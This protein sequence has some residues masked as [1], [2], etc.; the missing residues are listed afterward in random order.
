[1]DDRAYGA[2][3]QAAF[4]ADPVLVDAIRRE[5]YL[6]GEAL[7]PQRLG[8][9]DA[10][11]WAQARALAHLHA[12][13]PDPV[14]RAALT[15]DYELGCKRAVF[16]DDYYP[17]IASGAITLEPSALAAVRGAGRGDECAV[18]GAH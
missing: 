18:A 1:R 4:D 2:D 3:E 17:A 8:D 6:A 5:A 10:L 13:M 12:Q 7:V 16:S 11:D 14:L 15:P 9:L